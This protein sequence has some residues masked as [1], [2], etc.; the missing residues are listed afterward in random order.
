[1]AEKFASLDKEASGEN[2]SGRTLFES[3]LEKNVD[4]FEK[5]SR[6]LVATIQDRSERLKVEREAQRRA[7]EL[8]REAQRA[9]VQCEYSA[10]T[11][12]SGSRP[13][14]PRGCP[15]CARW[16]AGFERA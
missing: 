3:E 6:E 7:G 5:R 4:E 15:G 10:S 1:M 2:A 13:T 16:H 9:A 12:Q 14:Q 8:K 11:S